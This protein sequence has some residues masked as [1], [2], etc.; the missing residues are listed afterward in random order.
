MNCNFTQTTKA[1][2]RLTLY[3]FLLLITDNQSLWAQSPY[4]APLYNNPCT[5]TGGFGV[6]ISQFNLTK[7]SATLIA[8]GTGCTTD[9]SSGLHLN[10]TNFATPPP[11]VVKGVFYDFNIAFKLSTGATTN[12]GFAI[13]VDWNNNNSFTDVGEVVNSSMT[14]TTG[15]F[16]IPTTAST[17]NHR[18]RVRSL[19]TISAG[20]P[21]AAIPSDPCATYDVGDV[22]D[23]TINIIDC[24][25]LTRTITKRIN[26]PCVGGDAI[27]ELNLKAGGGTAPYTY[28]MNGQTNTNGIFTGLIPSDYRLIVTDNNG[29]STS[30]VETLESAT[31]FAFLNNAMTT[32]DWIADSISQTLTYLTGA[33][34]VL[35]PLNDS[36]AKYNRGVP[37]SISKYIPIGFS[38][39]FDNFYYDSL[40]VSENG[41]V[42]FNRHINPLTVSSQWYENAFYKGRGNGGGGNSSDCDTAWLDNPLPFIAAF[43]DDLQA[44]NSGNVASQINYKLS[45]VAPN[46]VFTI[47]WRNMRWHKVCNSPRNNA[48]TVQLMLYEG[49]NKVEMNYKAEPNLAPNCARTEMG[50]GYTVG[51]FGRR[52]GSGNYL[53]YNPEEG[54]ATRF[55]NTY[56]PANPTIHPGVITNNAYFPDAK[57]LRFT[58][59]PTDAA[60]APL[61]IT[62]VKATCSSGADGTITITAAGGILSSGTYFFSKDGGINYSIG[63]GN[64]S[65]FIGSGNTG[66]FFGLSPGTYTIAVHD[67][68]QGNGSPNNWS[69]VTQTIVVPN[70]T[71]SGTITQPL[72]CNGDI[73]GAIQ[74]N[75]AKASAVYDLQFQKTG[76]ALFTF[77]G[78]TDTFKLF[79]GLSAG[80][81][82]V[83]VTFKD[84]ACSTIAKVTL[85]DPPV[86]CKS[87]TIQLN[88][89][90]NATL[91]LAQIDNNPT[92]NCGFTQ[93]SLS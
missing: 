55:E 68:Q 51:L 63:S 42:S 38:F 79:T 4:C 64:A 54:T 74:F 92:D 12:S 62:S 22:H 80:T 30:F 45:G 59:P 83:T 28:N 58:P 13:W 35:T 23:Y 53:A 8:D 70:A 33:N 57:L 84:L 67:N 85:S 39:Q 25:T 91:T 69:F 34:A 66:T 44:N 47:E 7:N 77:N 3:F 87:A 26:L 2:F 1:H 88:N 76:G 24:P 31:N 93:R 78:L 41:A 43:R 9:P 86:S 36:L 18:M 5:T 89:M 71:V 52:L 50:Y 20:V 11:S 14:E 61:S 27:G 19:K 15:N 75:W 32:Q 37:D 40:V 65:L 6:Y 82:N 48:I 56:D 49:S 16:Q 10:Y 17:G 81:Y 29:C 60:C 21:T 73:T 90:G 72:T 46:R